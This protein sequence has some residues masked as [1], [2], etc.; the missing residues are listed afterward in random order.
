MSSAPLPADIRPRNRTTKLMRDQQNKRII[1]Y[2]KSGATD[3]DIMLAEK[4]PRRTFQRR[5][6]D[7]RKQHLT[8]ILDS[9]HAA[10]KASLLK[11]C[12]DK[13]R[14]L[15]MKAQQII[16]N[17]NE[18]TA[19]RIA[20]MALSRQYQIDIAKLTIDGP[21][22]FRIANDGFHRRDNNTP[23]EPGKP[24]LL[25]ESATPT[26]ATATTISEQQQ[27]QQQQQQPTD[28]NAVF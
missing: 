24:V 22:V 13:I 14:W 18:R 5:L 2:W 11:I 4:M 21:T 1:D 17:P 3:M 20:A 9:Q 12:Q 10:A 26:T 19:D 7:I 15:D 23:I 16:V 28:P 6:A 27:Q 25:S 8:E